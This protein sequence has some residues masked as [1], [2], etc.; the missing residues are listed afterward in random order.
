MSASEGPT[1]PEEEQATCCICMEALSSKPVEGLPC[2]HVFH[3]EC[4]DKWRRSA[5][6]GRPTHHCPLRCERSPAVRAVVPV[7]EH[8]ETDDPQ[9]T[10]VEDVDAPEPD[11]EAEHL[12][13]EAEHDA[14][15]AELFS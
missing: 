4:L 15:M 14:E 10:S 8:V 1:G 3:A 6:L 13:A 12:S 2:A 5:P 7:E 9:G 11:H